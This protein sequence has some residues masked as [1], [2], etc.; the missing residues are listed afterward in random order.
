MRIFGATVARFCDGTSS[1][2][3]QRLIPPGTL[4]MWQSASCNLRNTVTFG[5]ASDQKKRALGE[6]VS[7]A[8]VVQIAHSSPPGCR[9]PRDLVGSQR[10]QG[11]IGD[12]L[13]ADPGRAVLG[14]PPMPPSAS[15]RGVG[16]SAAKPTMGAVGVVGSSMRYRHVIARFTR[17]SGRAANQTMSR[18][19]YKGSGTY[20]GLTGR[21]G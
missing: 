11:H 9:K 15:R 20:G 3:W 10:D 2:S 7:S 12:L 5:L 8:P 4:R 19:A 17:G 1:S 21:R 6:T 16:P 18:P 13:A 14:P